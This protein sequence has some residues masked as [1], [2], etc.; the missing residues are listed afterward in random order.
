[1][2]PT[3]KTPGDDDGREWWRRNRRLA[4]DQGGPLAIGR[5]APAEAGD[6][7][8]KAWQPPECRRQIRLSNLANDVAIRALRPGDARDRNGRGRDRPHKRRHRRQRR[9]AQE[10]R[11]VQ[12][13]GHVMDSLWTRCVP[14]LQ[15][16]ST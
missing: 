9:L 13:D 5:N 3:P 12:L 4:C 11:V 8:L 10:N 15:V 16:D 6:R 2:S 1:V 14:H 7:I